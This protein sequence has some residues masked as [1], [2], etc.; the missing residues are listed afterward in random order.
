MTTTLAQDRKFQCSDTKLFE[1]RLN[2]CHMNK[3]LK[4]NV[5]TEM[6]FTS[7]LK[8]TSISMVCPFPPQNV[9]IKN[10]VVGIPPVP[11]PLPNGYFCVT[12]KV[13]ARPKGSK[14]VELFATFELRLILEKTDFIPGNIQIPDLPSLN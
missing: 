12:L 2:L 13:N 5:I 14:K 3:L 8:A 11:L 7:L 1:N 10:I 9:A 6:I 4:F